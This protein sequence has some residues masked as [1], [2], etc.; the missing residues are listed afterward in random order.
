MNKQEKKFIIV[1][2]CKERAQENNLATFGS[3]TIFWSGS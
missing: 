3:L 1:K 2:T